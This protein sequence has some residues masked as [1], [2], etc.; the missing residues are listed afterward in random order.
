M[1]SNQ[2]SSPSPSQIDGTN[3]QQFQVQA[4]VPATPAVS[5][6]AQDP[7]KGLYIVD[8]SQQHAALQMFGTDQRFVTAT[9]NPVELATATNASGGAQT[10]MVRRSLCR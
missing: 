10:I 5:I 9:G 1:D 8:P 6:I 4:A 2:A 7:S 3:S